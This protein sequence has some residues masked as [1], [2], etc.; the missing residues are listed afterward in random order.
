MLLGGIKTTDS[1]TTINV[2]AVAPRRII[3]GARRGNSSQKLSRATSIRRTACEYRVNNSAICASPRC[4]GS[5]SAVEGQNNS[6]TFWL[7]G[8]VLE[9]RV[10]ECE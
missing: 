3:T 6:E 4:F 9:R 8:P 2:I 7:W 5:D 10:L 1:A